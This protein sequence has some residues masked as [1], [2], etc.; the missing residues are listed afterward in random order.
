MVERL[1]VNRDECLY[2]YSHDTYIAG[3]VSLAE[4]INE[5]LIDTYGLKFGTIR[6]KPEQESF[7]HIPEKFNVARLVF[8][9]GVF[10]SD[11]FSDGEIEVIRDY[12]VSGGRLCIMRSGGGNDANRLVAP[13]GIVFTNEKIIDK[14]H[15]EGRHN[16]HA[17]ISRFS[18][19]SINKGM[20]SFCFGD[21]GGVALEVG[22][23]DSVVLA[24]SNDTAEPR[25]APVACLKPFGDGEV[26][27]IGGVSWFQNKYIKK[28]DNS[29]WYRNILSY[30]MRV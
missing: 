10:E 22:N 21:H 1:E 14:M 23:P 12:V 15:H 7:M 8:I 18:E 6:G 19:H 4:E 5:E 16:D 11:K 3:N 2:D 25:N 13:F 30:L 29:R 9:I 24:Y 28:Y 17:I 26:F 20:G 27:A